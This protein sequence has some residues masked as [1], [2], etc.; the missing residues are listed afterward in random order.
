MVLDTGDSKY[1]YAGKENCWH[2]AF[3]LTLLA[4][5]R[6]KRNEAKRVL[7]AGADPSDVKQSIKEAKAIAMQN[8]FELIAI[9]LNRHGFNRHLRVI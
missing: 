4:D 5:A 6:N 9:E 7:A 2:W 8:S 1:R 3:I